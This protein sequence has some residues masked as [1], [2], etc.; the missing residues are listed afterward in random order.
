M[1]FLIVIIL[2]LSFQTVFS[3]EK[4]SSSISGVIKDSETGEPVENVN[5]FIANSMYGTST[6]EE[7]FYKIENLSS[8]VYK[9]IVSHV[10]YYFEEKE[11]KIDDQKSLHYNF[12]LMQKS[13][14]LPQLLVEAEVDEEWQEMFEI[15]FDNMIGQTKNSE[16]T[17][18]TNPY[19]ISFNYE[20]N[21]LTAESDVP[22]IIE[23]KALGY[24][25]NYFLES[26]RHAADNTEYS[27]LPVFEEIIPS[28]SAQKKKWE[29][30]RLRAYCGSLRHFL[31]TICTNKK[32]T[33]GKFN[34]IRVISDYVSEI[35][36]ENEEL[37]NEDL[38]L[39]YSD[40]LYVVKQG[41]NVIHLMELDFQPTDSPFMSLLN[42][43]RILL[44]GVNNTEYIL[45]FPRFLQIVYDKEREEQ[46]YLESLGIYTRLPGKQVSAITLTEPSVRIDHKGRQLGGF[47]IQTFG[48]WTYE[49]LADMLP[50]EYEV[51]DSILF[52]YDAY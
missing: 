35:I 21:I 2:L 36:Y 6:N 20:D 26:F 49:R 15:F 24:K 3:Q 31:T 51:S 10:N 39:N 14:E 45:K 13:Y 42:T 9:L 4:I 8:G 52:N 47:D 18:I 41:F 1:R 19:V 5:V 46:E 43:N 29:E 16:E 11:I 22:I 12:L 7:G 27:G 32:M 38:F 30:N 40:T 48:Y 34:R 44:N 33:S 37:Y 25:I 17:S 23:N 50:F 28:D